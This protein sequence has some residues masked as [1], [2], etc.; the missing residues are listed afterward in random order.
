MLRLGE[1]QLQD[2]RGGEALFR[3]PPIKERRRLDCFPEHKVFWAALGH[4]EDEDPGEL[5]VGIGPLEETE[6]QLVFLIVQRL[7]E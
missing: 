5:G 2:E 3:D 6:L 4:R 7:Q 1:D